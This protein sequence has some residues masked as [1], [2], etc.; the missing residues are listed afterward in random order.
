[1]NENSSFVVRNELNGQIESYEN[2]LTTA[3]KQV[4]ELKRENAKIVRSI[5]IE[6]TDLRVSACLDG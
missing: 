4:E 3:N 2:K 6:I 1:M 5:F